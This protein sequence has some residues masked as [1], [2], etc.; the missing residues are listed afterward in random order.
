MWD[1]IC[2]FVVQLIELRPVKILRHVER[3]AHTGTTV[4]F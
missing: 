4:E 1:A 3:N 2:E